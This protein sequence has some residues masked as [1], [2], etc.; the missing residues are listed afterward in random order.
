[1]GSFF[2]GL[3]YYLGSSTLWTRPLYR[4]DNTLV[5]FVDL[6]VNLST[7]WTCLLC[8]FSDELVH[9]MDLIISSSILWT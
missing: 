5:Y 9:F 6:A 7:L 2:F 3:I 8:W 4:L 1:M